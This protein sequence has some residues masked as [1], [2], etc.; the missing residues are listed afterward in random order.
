VPTAKPI[1]PDALL[2]SKAR[3]TG[4]GCSFAR[5]RAKLPADLN[6]AITRWIDT[7]Q[8]VI[9]DA[10][11]ADTVSAFAEVYG[12]DFSTDVSDDKIAR[13]RPSS[14]RGRKCRTCGLR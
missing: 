9:A 11:I 12:L 4:T 13:H 10:T 8:S 6:D 14:T 7:D 3:I 1:D 5:M 2:A